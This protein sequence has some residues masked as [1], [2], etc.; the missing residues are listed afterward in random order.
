MQDDPSPPDSQWQYTDDNGSKSSDSELPSSPEAVDWTASEFIAHHK[1]LPWF[2]GLA[3]I[4]VVV[5]ALVFLLT[6]DLIS[7]SMIVVVGAAFGYIAQRKP[8]SIHYRIDSQ[9]ILMG[10]KHYGYF[11]FKSFSA[12]QEDGARSIRLLP[13]K[14]FMPMVS[15]YYAP[16][17]EKKIIDN[18]SNQLPYEEHK[19]DAV[20]QLMHRLRF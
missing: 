10:S 19:L 5:A 1:E 15:M 8:K 4:T 11:E 7:T 3:V 12:V 17:D 6:H 13:L 2:M 14:R 16:V 18:L 9:G 20:D